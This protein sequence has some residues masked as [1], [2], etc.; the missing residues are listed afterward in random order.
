MS[1]LTHAC[2]AFRHQNGSIEQRW[3]IRPSVRLSVCLSLCLSHAR[4]QNVAFSSYDH[5]RTLMGNSELEVEP[6]HHQRGHMATRSGQKVIEAENFG[7][8]YVEKQTR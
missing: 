6:Q 1:L 7:R 4:A 2:Y 8:P 5:C 3:H